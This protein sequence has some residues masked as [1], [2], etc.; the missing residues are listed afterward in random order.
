ML[1]PIT[2]RSTEQFLSSVPQTLREGALA[3]GASQWKAIAT[4]V[5]PAAYSRHRH[6]HDPGRGAHRRR[7]R[8][9]A[10]HQC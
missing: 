1:I 3:L 10:F 8:A 9:A 5:V 4:V 7:N 2:A 6:R